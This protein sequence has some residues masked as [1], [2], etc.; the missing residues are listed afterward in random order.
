[1][2]A[3]ALPAWQGRSRTVA[4]KHTH[5]S[6]HT[7]T[8]RHCLNCDAVTW[9]YSFALWSSEAASSKN[10]LISSPRLQQISPIRIIIA[11]RRASLA[12]LSC[13]WC[14]YERRVVCERTAQLIC[15]QLC[16]TTC[17]QPH[18]IAVAY[19]RVQP[20]QI[21]LA[22]CCAGS[23]RGPAAQRAQGAPPPAESAQGAAC[24][25]AVGCVCSFARQ[26][27]AQDQLPSAQPAGPTCIR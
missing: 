18:G 4:Q 19:I 10:G 13:L 25:E 8:L 20:T 23:A 15:L 24:V 16:A 17:V 27:W 7:L 22:C 21:G 9:P 1:M 12:G 5:A 26:A 11:D 2:C 6:T 14:A 3:D